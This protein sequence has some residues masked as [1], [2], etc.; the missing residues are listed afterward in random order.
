MLK[1]VRTMGS[2]KERGGSRWRGFNSRR[3]EKG[4]RHTTHS[5]DTISHNETG[6]DGGGGSTTAAV[7]VAQVTSVENDEMGHR[8]AQGSTLCRNSG[9]VALRMW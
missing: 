3:A 7:V 1:V 4:V 9:N 6:E 8:A 2:Y 5:C